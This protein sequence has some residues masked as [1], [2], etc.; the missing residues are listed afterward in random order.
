[1]YN[2]LILIILI[3]IST[4]G[5]ASPVRF[6]RTYKETTSSNNNIVV[7]DDPTRNYN[8]IYR[9]RRCISEDTGRFLGYSSIVIII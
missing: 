3:D 9:C 8:K 2:I 6:T 4:N 1:M 7:E 5:D